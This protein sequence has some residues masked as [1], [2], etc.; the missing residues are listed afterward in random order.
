MELKQRLQ[1]QE[2]LL[3]T[4]QK[5]THYQVTEVL[6]KT[7]LDVICLDAEHAPFGR[8]ELDAC[9]LAARANDKPV[10]IRVPDHR[11]ATL[12]NALDIGATGVVVPHVKTAQQLSDIAAK[13]YFGDAG[14]GY[15]GSTR[16][17]GYTTHPLPQ[18]L[19]TSRTQ[20]CLIAQIEDVCALGHL[21]QIC[22]VEHVDAIFI[23]T[24]DFVVALGA[25]SPTANAVQETIRTIVNTAKKYQRTIGMFVADLDELSFWKE[26]GVSLFLLNSDHSFMLLGAAHLRQRF[27]E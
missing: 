1:R 23:G 3:G 8:S 9:V 26:Q 4:F 5:T 15:A 17:A 16:F 19:D 13:C 24:M 25:E 18:N 22:Q 20:T 2:Q 12:L 11:P 27:D 6:S 21:E 14:R 7:A 10:L